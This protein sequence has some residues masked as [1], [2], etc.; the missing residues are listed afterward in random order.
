MVEGPICV[1]L[2]LEQKCTFA[3]GSDIVF[4][5]EWIYEQ[6]RFHKIAAVN[7]SLGGG[8]FKAP[9]NDSDPAFA[10]MARLLKQVGIAVVV[11]SGNASSSS[12]ISSPACV[13][14]AISVGAS[15]LN[16]KVAEF[17][18]SASF[19][20]LLA[21]GTNSPTAAFKGIESA[22]PSGYFERMSGTS[23]AA[24]HVAGAFAVFRSINPSASNKKC[25]LR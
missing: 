25:C 7:L 17:S 12:G 19:L 1:F 11:A 24:P 23:M 22:I 5:L 8:N 9:C 6:R 15:A 20:D 4:A 14:E 18:N 3:F 10:A 16:D 21:P 13:E 2:T